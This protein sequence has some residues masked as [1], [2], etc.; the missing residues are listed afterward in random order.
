M[1]A[2][3]P[4]PSRRLGQSLGINNIPS[5]NC[6]YACIYCQVGNT[7]ELNYTRNEFYKPEDIFGDV[8]ELVVKLK[9]NREA[10]DYIT[11]VPDGEPTLDV[12]L[13]N[14]IDL[15]K[16]LGYKIAV[17]TNGSLIMSHDVQNDLKKADYVSIKID[18]IDKQIWK[19]INRPY[20]KISLEA[21][22]EGLNEFSQNYHGRLTTETM[23]ID[24]INS[25]HSNIASVAGFISKL[26]PYRAYIA[27][28][29]RPP[30]ETWVSIP[31]EVTLNNAFQ[32]FEEKINRVEYLIDFE[33]NDFGYSGEI[34][35]DILNITAVHPLRSESV[36]GL[37]RKANADWR[38]IENLIYQEKLTEVEYAGNKFYVRCLLDNVK[39]G[40]SR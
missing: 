37:L 35:K 6:S 15:L 11:F 25:S 40:E 33:G 17:I 2:F 38:V 32:I 18:T 34:E 30:A 20:N 14:E 10:I 39:M 4:V 13:G 29:T 22:L 28:P 12:N 3:G 24:E 36:Q 16:L 7:S 27:I 23:L 9:K 19:K 31:N 8:Q 1:I 26:R 5:K 21:I